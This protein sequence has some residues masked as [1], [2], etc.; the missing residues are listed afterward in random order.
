MIFHI[1]NKITLHNSE[2]HLSSQPSYIRFNNWAA[3]IQAEHTPA[4]GTASAVAVVDTEDIPFEVA[5]GNPSAAA[6]QTFPV[7]ALAAAHTFLVAAL[8]AEE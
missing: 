7:A 2:F 6:V 4:E 1:Q 3:G 8:V 5:A